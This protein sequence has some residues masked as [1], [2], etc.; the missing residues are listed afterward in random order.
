MNS[1]QKLR[2]KIRRIRRNINQQQRARWDQMIQQ[3]LLQLIESMAASTVAAYWPFD[4]EPN[5]IPL[6]KQLLDEGIEIALPKITAND[7]SMEF[8]A[9]RPGMSLEPNTLGIPEPTNSD[10]KLVSGFDILIMPLVGYDRLGN[11]L[12]VGAGY[13]DRHL[14]PMRDSATPLRVGVAYSLQEIALNKPE[15]WDVPLHGIVNECGWY[16]FKE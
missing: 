3:N 1:R 8:H 9:W 10:I 5:L 2:D 16:E 13:Y 6:C 4:G 15:N 14:E 11:R 12:G 7:Y